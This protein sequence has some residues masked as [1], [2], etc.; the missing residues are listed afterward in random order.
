MYLS[1]FHGK[2]QPTEDF[3]VFVFKLDVQVV[4]IEEIHVFFSPCLEQYWGCVMSF[5]LSLKQSA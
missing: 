5:A 2:C 4:D 3:A 1:R